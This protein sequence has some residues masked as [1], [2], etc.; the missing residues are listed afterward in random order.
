MVHYDSIINKLVFQTFLLPPSA[1]AYWQRSYA[2]AWSFQHAAKRL[3]ENDEA[4]PI[5]TYI[6][7]RPSIEVL[8]IG[9]TGSAVDM[10]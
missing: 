1:S 5:E 10:Q 2:H 7:E 4:V 8:P 3:L 9:M 6:N